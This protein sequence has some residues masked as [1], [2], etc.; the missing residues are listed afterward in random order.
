M[1]KNYKY[2]GYIFIQQLNVPN[3]AYYDYLVSDETDSYYACHLRGDKPLN[4]KTIIKL[5]EEFDSFVHRL[6]DVCRED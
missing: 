6:R 5:I 1:I 2:K 3:K 4:E